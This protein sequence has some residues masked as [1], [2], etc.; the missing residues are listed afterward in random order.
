MTG[1]PEPFDL[2]EDEFL[3]GE[4]G[5]LDIDDIFAKD[6]SQLL[7]DFSRYAPEDIIADDGDASYPSLF[8][9]GYTFR[10]VPAG[11]L[12]ICPRG[13]IAGG[14]LSC[15]LVVDEPHRGMNPVLSLDESAYSNAGLEC[16]R[17]AWRHARSNPDE[18]RRRMR[19]WR[20]DPR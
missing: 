7:E 10:D 15:D 11:V 18:T 19:R 20:G 14:Y 5:R 2:S 17:S 3:E 13:D 6:L 4:E 1:F 12:L 16:H 9:P 8:E